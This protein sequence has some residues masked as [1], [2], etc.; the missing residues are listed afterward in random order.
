MSERIEHTPGQQRVRIDVTFTTAL[1]VVVA[2]GAAFVL[3]AFVGAASRPLGWALACGVVAALLQPVVNYFDRSL[4][5]GLA[6]VVTLLL[7][8]VVLGGFYGGVA[9][10]MVDNVAAL[11]DA[12]PEAAAELELEHELARDFGL[13]ERVTSFVDDLDE[14]L[15]ARAQLARTTSTISTYVVTGVLTVF[16]I[17]YGGRLVGGAIGLIRNERRRERVDRVAREAAKTWR[18]YVGVAA[19]QGIVVS[20]VAWGV[21]YALDLP[22]P[23][24]LGLLVGAFS[25]LI[26]YVGA[27]VGGIPALLF[28]A[29]TLDL[30]RVAAVVALV[31]AVQLVEAFAVRRRVDAATVYVGP[32]LPLI[33]GLIGFELYG[34]G[35][36]IY[37]VVLLILALAVVDASRDEE[38][39]ALLAAASPNE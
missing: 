15:G 2:V 6:V 1:L 10:T 29:A 4:P 35:G 18:R 37:G 13:E 34:V 19:A 7:L 20:L 5:R 30:W 36:A 11:K 16:L 3:A 22:A 28:A 23:F 33:V 21:L 8:V 14:R 31:M 27:L 32:A 12:A 9:G 25:A 38:A 39:S 26:P 24:V 17:A